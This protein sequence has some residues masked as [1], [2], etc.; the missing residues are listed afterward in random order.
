LVEV[1]AATVE[2]LAEKGAAE[3]MPEDSA[4]RAREETMA[5]VLA[6]RAEGAG[7]EVAAETGAGWVG[8]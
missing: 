4:E 2:E 7:A 3:A 1:S 8:P 6:V 5:Q